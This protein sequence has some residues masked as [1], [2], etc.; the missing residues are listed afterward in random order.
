[1]SSNIILG[2]PVA[3]GLFGLVCWVRVRVALTYLAIA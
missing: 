3:I 1:M 2:A